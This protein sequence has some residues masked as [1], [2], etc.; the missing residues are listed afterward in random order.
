MVSIFQEGLYGVYA[1]V[2]HYRDWIDSTIN[3]GNK[4]AAVCK[5]ADGEEGHEP[6][7]NNNNNNNNNNYININNNNIAKTNNTI[8]DVE[9]LPEQLHI[10]TAPTDTSVVIN[11]E[12][13]TGLKISCF[14]KSLTYDHHLSRFFDLLNSMI[15]EARGPE[16]PARWER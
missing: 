12:K 2:A 10:T 3:G 7:I 5:T 11:T 16:G 14:L 15:Y 13:A 6:V 4:R 8:Y 9:R 1:E